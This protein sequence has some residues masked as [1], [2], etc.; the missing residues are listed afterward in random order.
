MHRRLI[1][2]LATVAMFVTV[3]AGL[4]AS[5]RPVFAVGQPVA[6][7]NAPAQAL[8]GQP[9][10]FTVTFDNADPADTGY[11]PFVDLVFRATGV[12]G[13]DGITFLNAT[14]LGAALNTVSITFDADGCVPHPYARLTDGSYQQVCGTPGDTLVVIQLPFGSFTPEQPPVEIRVQAAVS[15]LADLGVP[16]PIFAR[17]GF[18]F[19]NDPL[20]N[21]CCDPVLL[22]PASPNSATWPNQPVTPTLFSVR[23]SYL[24]PENETATG[25]NFPRQ[26]RV[27]VDLPN[28]QTVTNLEISDTLPPQMQFVS[29]DAVLVNGSP[30]GSVAVSTPSTTT[31]GGV[32]TRRIP[33]VTGTTASADA[34]M[35]FP[36]YVPRLDAA[37]A[38]VLNPATGAPRVL[39][40]NA[41]ASATWT[42]VDPRDPPTPVSASAG[43]PG[44]RLTARSL[45]TQK[46]LT[47][48]NDVGAAG[49]TPGDTLEYTIE[50][51]ISDFFAFN[52]VT[53]DDVLSDGLRFDPSFPPTLQVDG[54]GFVSAT[55]P[56]AAAN[57][58]V[59][60]NYTPASPAP[61]DGTTTIEF[62]V[63]N[64]LVTRGQTG[65][66]I[67]GCVPTG[68]TGGP[69]PACG[70]YNDGPTTA[71]VVFRA[72]IQED[73]SDVFPSGDR[74]VDE[75]DGVG[76]QVTVT[77]ALL[78]VANLAATGVIV[79][80]GSAAGASVGRGALGKSIYALN[81]STTVPDPVQ[82]APGDTVTYRIQLT[83]PTSDAEN[84]RL[85]DYLPL[86][87]FP[88]TTF[89]F[90][91]NI[92]GTVPPANTAT[93]GPADTWRALFPVA[94]VPHPTVSVSTVG[95]SVSFNFGTFDD[96]QSLPSR[97]DLLLT[98]QASD[99]PTADRLLLTNQVRRIAGSTG[100]AEA[101]DD[102]IVQVV[103]TQ[104]ILRISKGVTGSTNPGAT[105]SPP[106]AGPVPFA[107]PGSAGAPFTGT[108]GSTALASTPV[109]S[110]IAGVDA[111][112]LVGFAI[113]LENRG[114]GTR[115]AYDIAITD[116]LPPGLIIPTGG[117]G[118][119]L[120]VRNGAGAVIPF[121]YLGGGGP[122]NEDDLFNN[123]IQLIDTSVGACQR[124]HPNDGSN[125]IVI[126]YDLQVDPNVQPGQV[127][128][129][130]GTLPSYAGDEGGT[131][132]VDPAGPPFDRASV[133]AATPQLT[134]SIVATSAAH[135]EEAASPPVA[136]GEIVRYRLAVRVPEGRWDAAQIQDRLP[137]GLRFLNDGTA[138]AALIS[139]GAGLTSDTL[140]G[141]GLAVSGNAPAA[142]SFLLPDAAVSASATGNND[143]YG[144]GTDV[145]F[146]LGTLTNADNDPDNEYVVV[147]FNAL[148]EN[149]A[150]NTAGVQRANDFIV[151][152]AGSP[153]TAPG[154]SQPIA[155]N[156]VAARVVE[157]ARTL[158]KTIA[159]PASATGDAGDTITYRI[160][161]ANPTGANV[162]DAFDVRISDTLPANL[163][164]NVASV[165]V[166]LNGGATGA[167]NGSAGNTVDVT[168]NRVPPGGSVRI[169]YTATV[170]TGVT[171]GQQITNTANL[172]YTSLPGANGAAAGDNPT[173]SATP[174]APGSDT[175]ERIAT[176]SD[177]AIL[178]VITPAPTKTFVATSEAHTS[179]TPSPPRVAIG[180]IVR[181]RLA[182]RLAEGS[183]P[184]FQ[185]LDNLPNGLTFLNDG[186]ARVAFVANGGGISSSTIT[187]ALPGC[188]GLNV[189][190]NSATL[191]ALPSGSI[192]C[193]LPAGAISPA[194]FG[195]GTDPTFSLG[196]L[197][198][199]D[200]DADEEFV[201]VEF[202]ALVDN[203]VAGNNIA[204]ANRDNTF[205]VRV[206]GTSIAT[207]ANV[208]VRIAE[209]SFTLNKQVIATPTDAGDTVT[210][211]VTYTSATGA[212][213]ATAFDVRLRDPLPAD[214]TLNLASVSVTPGGGASGITNNSAGNT[215]EI[216]VAQIPPGGSVTV[217]YSATVN[218]GAVNGRTLTN[219]ANLTYTSL[220][221]PNGTTTNPT[222]SATP[223]ASGSNT[224]ERDGSGGI[225]NYSRSAT[226]NVTLATPTIEKLAP[227]PVQYTIGEVVTFNL[228]V[229]L[230]EGVTQG[231]VVTDDLPPGLAFLNYSIVTTDPLLAAPYAGNVGSLSVTRTGPTAVPGA[232][233]EDLVLTFPDV[234]TTDDNV[235]NNNAFLVRL[236]A[237]VL[238]VIGNQN[239]TTLTNTARLRY[240]NPNT[241][242]AVTVNAPTARTVTVVEPVLSIAKSILTPPD[243]ADAGGVVTY[244][245]V[246]S[247]A[248]G[249]VGTAYDVVVTDPIPAGLTNA[250]VVGVSAVGITPPSA[251]I[252][253]GVARVPASDSFDLPPGASVTLDFRAEIGG[254]VSPGQMITNRAS[255]VWSTL[256]G[257]SPDERSE[258]DGVA[259]G[260]ELL[261]SGALNDY[262]INSSASFTIDQPDLTKALAATSAAHTGGANV[263]IGEIVTY[264][265]GVALPEGVIPSL[266]L[267]DDLPAGLAFVPGSVTVDITGFNGTAPDPTVSG[268]AGS[269]DDVTISFGTI[270]VAVDNDAS[271][272]SFRVRLQARVLDVAGNVGLPPAQTTLINRA[273]LTVGANPPVNSNDVTVTV[274]EPRLEITK[275][276]S[277]DRAYAGQTV[278]VRLTVRNT[279]VSDAFDVVIVDPL[280]PRFVAA[281]EGSTPTGF[282]FDSYVDGAL[283]VRYTGGGIP[284]GQS[285]IFTFRVTL[286]DPATAGEVITNRATV[287]EASTLP[288]AD[289]GER[290]LPAVDGS[291]D[292][293]IVATDLVLTKDDGG[294]SAE[295]GGAI[296]FIL[297]FRNVGN[298]DATGVTLTETVPANTTFDAT[299]S[300]PGW[301]C[302]NGAPAGTSCT[303]T[304]GNLAAGANGSVNFV[305]RVNNP[306]PAGVTE[307]ANAARINDDGSNGADPT[308]GNN[309]A[310][311]TTPL[312]AAPDLELTK[313]DGGASAEPGGTITFI[314][315]YRNVGNQDATGVTLTE[316]VPANTSFNA[317]A[318]TAGWSCAPDGSAGS[319]CTFTVG[320]LAAGAS[321]SVNFVVR[322]NNPLPAGVTEVV[323]AARI[324]DDGSNGADPT[325]EN[326]RDDDTTPL[327]AAPDL[328]VTKD[329]G[330]NFVLPGQTLTYTLRVRNV[331][332][333]GATG[334]EVRDALPAGL[335]FV[336]ASDGGTE[337]GGVVAW[338][339]FDL[340]GGAEV[341]RT[342]TAR[343]ADPFV[344]TL[345]AIVNTA[346]VE[347]D[348]TNGAD[349]TPDNN[350]TSD[351]DYV[352][353]DLAL[354][355]SDGGASA[356]PGGLIRFVLSYTNTGGI[357]VTGVTLRETVPLNTGF[358]ASLAEN[359][360]WTCAPDASAGSE[361]VY[362]VGNLPAGASG[363]V[364][365]VVR[366]NDP[367]PAGGAEVVNA[368]R[369]SDNGARGPDRNSSDNAASDS[370]PVSA[371][372]DLQLSKSTGGSAPVPGRPLPYRL[373]YRNVGN[374][375]A[376]GVTITE[377]VPANTSFS[378][379]GSSA[380]WSCAD[381]APAGSACSFNIG[382]LPAGAGGS[383]TFTVVVDNPVPQGTTGIVNVASISDD[384]VNGSDPTPDNNSATVN[385]PFSPTAITLMHFSAT[386]TGEGVEV[387]WSTGIEIDT[388]RFRIYRSETAT[389]AEAIQI[390]EVKS[391]GS[392][393]SGESYRVVDTGAEAGRNY[394]YWLVEGEA[395]GDEATYGPV[396]VTGGLSAGFQVYL[397]LLRR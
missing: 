191:A 327:T 371:A 114:S 30:A 37:S 331:G 59:T 226:A 306:L 29:L 63:S 170:G 367:L 110:N 88:V 299:A 135:T 78:N 245:V 36:F 369:I 373:E 57:F 4:T 320:N 104:P 256:D 10:T 326:N 258:G 321:G 102:A 31:P 364:N 35:I 38:A 275:V 156:S 353:P 89:T 254:S 68:G 202:N 11:G 338:P 368:A 212:D 221:G 175:G 355:K 70:S 362:T 100:L 145:F 129:N 301:S 280:D 323:N 339:P 259:D 143:T 140:S 255:A 286:D 167:T 372:P 382:S 158:D 79:G 391:Q 337:T 325:P 116:L 285:R 147:E 238:N 343:V 230:P 250:T 44:H 2:L 14:Y 74:S 139:N 65:A 246:I 82:L 345:G 229:T 85:V 349:P 162:T 243:P 216:V 242:A 155:S 177:P 164:L 358:D 190:G 103:M 341:T 58:T 305:V 232:S 15:P 214:L 394:W 98:V 314:L 328:V 233:G 187:T 335:S 244:R 54:N 165:T 120:K 43:T 134:K 381:G 386:R 297:S 112:D 152:R 215:V 55:A 49:P 6:T 207:S 376:T 185:L 374:Q 159:N 144:S 348:G 27:D 45:A 51:Q 289:S 313:S 86:P 330:E 33:S 231:L 361:C 218:A 183:A 8:I 123:G 296:T 393:T 351:T 248:A 357:D 294:A 395:D 363:T 96:P 66:L 268:G 273:S 360:G 206:N 39:D 130:R 199:S 311:D 236:Q 210:Y 23:K 336:A 16:L 324:S 22:T 154:G 200:S 340:P 189:S 377:T 333:R 304:V 24:G 5:P 217:E 274:V 176:A 309:Q 318:S 262:E 295:P 117:A 186:S 272:N 365:F 312:T 251:A 193:P 354:T 111:N 332:T 133:T 50:V 240:T 172:S 253:S 40:N 208:S 99:R 227:T 350:T 392:A 179:D 108:I 81:G 21:W 396:R 204:G 142:P 194:T 168:I 42:P 20:D 287:T 106:T 219:T 292:L 387:R 184:N 13:D 329:D 101:A 178:T 288:G 261:N 166:T 397:P 119:N 307:V 228:R 19:G 390:A 263:T 107:A 317:T 7:L 322:V 284:A 80:D 197:T 222:G 118:L 298:Q 195:T 385:S 303:F 265:L 378:A 290:E 128:L 260:N 153:I 220:P 87:I 180:E 346:T 257:D 270:N 366:V 342:V 278:E 237:R 271:N 201:V 92:A 25:P 310:S 113:V 276:F 291:D 1:H 281:V 72:I 203:T 293:T 182:V 383:V 174:G 48:V 41:S 76:N 282:T 241:G 84:L 18:Q 264:E 334:V 136:I 169:E 198:N 28:G 389:R 225:N 380:G 95:N 315:S 161:Y 213:R 196:N 77:G 124:Y 171:P 267:V 370:T 279:G 83:L 192:T 283:T 205:A 52:Q 9:F 235:A 247:H 300:T 90:D 12:D 75:G 146:N 138:R 121:T 234:T 47:V 26:Y 34:S 91:P 344:D 60:P 388:A 141:A 160:D 131:N 71:R 53:L 64:E 209:P 157:P 375:G 173:G 252:S 269:G 17:A 223:G 93:Y 127:I 105:L 46:R 151:Y 132:H 69:P 224:G 149:V 115:G 188:G 356:E 379:A 347:D 73:Y 3:M 150:G 266:V 163:T 352:R 125:I 67:G 277:P 239:G 109:D 384:G 94:T 148:V 126:T 61:N 56:F 32:L 319:T 137:D 122:G 181:Y 359:A 97:I 62:R 211:R 316:T 302:A 249:S 308:P